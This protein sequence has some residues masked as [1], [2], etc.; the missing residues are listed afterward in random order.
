MQFNFLNRSAVLIFSISVALVGCGGS[1]SSHSDPMKPATALSVELTNPNALIA[2][3]HVTSPSSVQSTNKITASDSQ[4][5]T[6]VCVYA[7]GTFDAD[8]AVSYKGI[9][10]SFSIHDT[11]LSECANYADKKLVDAM[12]VQYT[13]QLEFGYIPE[14]EDDTITVSKG[15][16]K[17]DTATVSGSVRTGAFFTSDSSPV[18]DATGSHVNFQFHNYKKDGHG[19]ELIY[20]I[21]TAQSQSSKLKCTLNNQ[22]VAFEMN[23]AATVDIPTSAKRYFGTTAVVSEQDLL[24]GLKLPT[25]TARD[26]LAEA[27]LFTLKLTKNQHDFVF[28]TSM[29]EVNFIPT[30]APAATSSD[31]WGPLYNISSIT[32]KSGDFPYIGLTGGN[33]FDFIL[34]PG[35]GTASGY[36]ITTQAVTPPATGSEYNDVSGL[37]GGSNSKIMN[38]DGKAA[39]EVS[40]AIL[41]SHAD[42]PADTDTAQA[43]N[44]LMHMQLVRSQQK[45][46]SSLGLRV[47]SAKV[48]SKPVVKTLPVKEFSDLL[49]TTSTGGYHFAVDQASSSV[50]SQKS[51][52][53]GPANTDNVQ[54][55]SPI[56]G[57]GSVTINSYT[58][59]NPD[60]TPALSTLKSSTIQNV[61][62]P[63]MDL[64]QNTYVG[65]P[66]EH[67]SKH[68]FV[69]FSTDGVDV[70]DGAVDK[71]Y[72]GP[73]T[74]RTLRQIDQQSGMRL[75]CNDVDAAATTCYLLA[76]ASMADNE[77]LVQPFTLNTADHSVV[78]TN[79]FQL[80]L[81][82]Q[83]EKGGNLKYAIDGSTGNLM[84][85]ESPRT[86]SAYDS[87]L[88]VYD[89]KT[90]AYA[91][92]LSLGAQHPVGSITKLKVV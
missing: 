47:Q 9:R 2:P 6:T 58:L 75:V 92:P 55:V 78:F 27:N 12:Q 72:A 7:N 35:D 28:A 74:T 91:K 21:P 18:V 76:Q 86:G 89:A 5:Q 25:E 16:L 88:Y 62:L 4:D 19:G 38:S 8:Q 60:T 68:S 17:S 52:A 26:D 48:P 84:L 81:P 70:F 40:S 1:G 67:V 80:Q 14:P 61:V 44:T 79:A 65:T 54:I 20:Q 39:T 59:S 63:V 34:Q 73:I 87:Y 29:G 57:D 23:C 49:A 66:K 83:L 3:I 45:G 10:G 53:A 30:S 15:T 24:D 56:D 11:D 71:S 85:L 90:A 42:T 64:D 33:I 31:T 37:S 36:F 41:F 22:D 32:G 82:E 51:V 46:A 69:V 50:V 43:G 77:L 13:P